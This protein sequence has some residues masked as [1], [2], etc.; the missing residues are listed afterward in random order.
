MSLVPIES[1]NEFSV[2]EY[3]Q[4]LS[5]GL[6]IGQAAYLSSKYKAGLQ[7]AVQRSHNKETGER[8]A[9]FAGSDKD[10]TTTAAKVT[11]RVNRKAQIAI[12]DSGVTTSII[13]KALL[14]H[15]EYKA[16]R[17][18]KLIVITVSHLV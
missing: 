3:L 11:L 7:R 14:D 5:S 4:N 9:N 18:S 10:E 16:N 6:T 8:K 1:L 15:L 17:P 12:V 2:S 13:T